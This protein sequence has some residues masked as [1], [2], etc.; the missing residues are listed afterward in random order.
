MSQDKKPIL[1]EVDI[2]ICFLLAIHGIK[3]IEQEDNI[4]ISMPSKKIKNRFYDRVHPTK[5]WYRNYLTK[6]IIT[7]YLN[8]KLTGNS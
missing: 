2:V 7:T 1:A 8:S 4:F 6:K 5:S 3:I